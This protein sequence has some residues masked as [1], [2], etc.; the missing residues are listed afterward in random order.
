MDLFKEKTTRKEVDESI[1]R[2]KKKYTRTLLPGENAPDLSETKDFK[3]KS[4][5]YYVFNPFGKGDF[6]YA[7]FASEEVF[8]NRGRSLGYVSEEE[9]YKD[10]EEEAETVLYEFCVKIHGNPIDPILTTLEG[11]IVGEGKGGKFS[12]FYG[13]LIKKHGKLNVTQ[14]FKKIRA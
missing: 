2:M 12:E 3:G 13:S 4:G 11:E 6:M 14:T 10:F 7:V 1:N 9:A 5:K 8:K